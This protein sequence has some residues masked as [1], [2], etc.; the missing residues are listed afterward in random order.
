MSASG[1]S[2]TVQKNLSKKKA[3]LADIFGEDEAEEELRPPPEAC[4]QDENETK[5]DS[6][7]YILYKLHC[8][9]Y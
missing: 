8:A 1:S 3:L 2:S 4:L 6:G 5:K 9:A 7:M